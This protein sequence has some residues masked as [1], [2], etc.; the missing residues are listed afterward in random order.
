MQTVAE[1][2][3]SR[4][5]DRHDLPQRGDNQHDGADAFQ[6]HHIQAVHH[7]QKQHPLRVLQAHHVQQAQR[8]LHAAALREAAASPQDLLRSGPHH[9]GRDRDV[10]PPSSAG[11]S[12]LDTSASAGPGARAGEDSRGNMQMQVGSMTMQKM[13]ALRAMTEGGGGNWQGRSGQHD[14]MHTV[15]AGGD[16]GPLSWPSGSAPLTASLRSQLD[17]HLLPANHP[18]RRLLRKQPQSAGPHSH[19]VGS[20]PVASHPIATSSPPP[21]QSGPSGELGAGARQ[22][23]GAAQGPPAAPE[24]PSTADASAS[25]GAAVVAAGGGAER[26]A[27]ADAA[28]APGEESF[29]GTV[30]EGVPVIQGGTL[31]ATGT[32]GVGVPVV[33]TGVPITAAEALHAEPSASPAAAA[34]APVA[35]VEADGSAEDDRSKGAAA[36]AAAD[37]DAAGQRAAKRI[38]E[39][40]MQSLTTKAAKVVSEHE[41]AN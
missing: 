4:M 11:G 25:T 40:G 20:Q 10:P 41:A 21:Q 23:S 18:V 27:G 16:H 30:A 7:A 29:A 31:P 22:P 28:A 36:S 19:P 13:A 38:A 6:R 26:P 12:A 3:G 5:A 34:G 8:Q 2:A 33:A 35:T 1:H 32:V 9:G 24:A 37:D 39:N 15:S 17:P 14:H